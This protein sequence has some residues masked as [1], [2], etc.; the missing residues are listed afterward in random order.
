MHE[1]QHPNYDE[2]KYRRN[3]N[4]FVSTWMVLQ[5][6]INVQYTSQSEKRKYI[7]FVLMRIKCILEQSETTKYTQSI[8]AV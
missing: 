5:C 3:N 2:F 1:Y 7:L 8:P 4:I 6:K